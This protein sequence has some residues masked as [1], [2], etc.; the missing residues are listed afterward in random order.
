[1]KRVPLQTLCTIR[2]GGT[3]SKANESFWNGNIPWISPKDMKCSLLLDGSDHITEEAVASS[4]TSLVPEGSIL[5]V[6]RS[7]ILVH[8]LPVARVGRPLAFNQDIKALLPDPALTEP[9]YLYWFIR[10]NERLVL[11]QGVKKGATVHSL[12]SGF[13][14][15]LLVPVPTPSEQRRI[16]DLLFRAEGIVNLRREARL[17]AQSVIPAL[18][19][20]M[21]G[22]PTPNPKG[23]EQVPLREL[24]EEFRYGTSQKS[25]E[26]GLPTLRIPNVVGGGLET[27]DMKLV[28]VSDAEAARLRL[29]DGDLL[30]V[31]TNGN[32]D[33]VGRS[34]VF[35]SEVLS[36]AGFDA[37]NCIYASYLIRARLRPGK[38]LPGFLQVFLS[39]H[40]GR[41]RLREQAR[42]SAGQYNI[43]TV[44]LGSIR[45][46]VPPIP[47]QELF[48]ERCR[49][50]RS[51]IS[52]QT[53]ALVTAEATLSCVLARAFDND[54]T[55]NA[56][57]IE[58]RAVA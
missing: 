25:G 39:S 15:R 37:S 6:A 43:N 7:G 55:R 28:A 50:L 1:M 30:F 14:E 32:P 45:I 24:V 5:V 41:K 18:M 23:W 12:Q 38:V 34:T 17:K 3:P 35:D 33:Y 46:P 54:L 4:A 58:E 11:N 57:M 10:A 8:S 26:Q 36:T 13:L 16:V 56:P 22:D 19:L 48:E 49:N 2:H 47:L 42:T 9:D 51:I 29:R 40:E 27:A 31:R 53:D 21:F 52:Q 20:D 44:G